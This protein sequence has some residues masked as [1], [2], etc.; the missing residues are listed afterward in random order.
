[1]IAGRWLDL[2]SLM[3]TSADLVFSKALDKGRK[4]QGKKRPC[5]STSTTTNNN[6]W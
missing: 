2:A 5:V 3:I 6:Y 4:A 1:M